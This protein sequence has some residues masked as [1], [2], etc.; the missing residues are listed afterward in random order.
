[1]KKREIVIAFAGNPNVGK[2]ALI[3]AISGAKLKIGNWPG[4][5]V[6]KRE[7]E[8]EFE[9][10]RFRLVDLPGIYSLTPYTL[11]ERIAQEF[12]LEERP[13][14][15][16]NV[17]DVTNIERN[18]YLTTQLA[19]LEIPMVIALNMWDEFKSKGF[20]LDVEMLSKILRVPCV[21]TAAVRG[22]GVDR[23]LKEVI[24]V[25]EDRV[26]PAKMRFKR[27]IEEKIQ[28]I[29]EALKEKDIPY[30][31]RWSAIK[32]LEKDE[33]FL[34]KISPFIS[35][36][37]MEIQKMRES[38]EEYFGEDIETVIAEQRYGYINGLVREVLKKP[39]ERKIEI[40]DLI[41]K[42]FL[43]RLLGMPI[44]FFLIYLVFKFTF[45]GSAPL[46]DWID[47]FIN[48][49]VAKWLSIVLYGVGAPQWLVSLLID[50]VLNGV[51]LVLSFVPLMFFL[52]FFMS[53]LEESGYMA[54]A[55]FLMDKI[56]HLVGLH[57]KSFIPMVIGFG[58]NVPAILA[59]R[60][61]ESEKDRKLTALLIPF[62]SCGARLPI[63]ALFTGLFFKKH[64]AEIVFLLYFMGVVV[65]LIVGMILQKTVFKGESHPFIMEL[66]PYRIP[67]L[68]MLWNSIWLRTRSFIRKAGTVIAVTMVI[69]WFFMNIPYGVSP[70]KTVLGRVART[71]SPVFYP[72]GFGENWKA[73]A[74]LIPGTVAKEIVVGALGQLYGIEEQK[75][76]VRSKTSLGEDLKDQAVELKDA[77][78]ASLKGILGGFKTTIFEMEE[79]E[80]TAFKKI[81]DEFTPLSA[82]SYMVFCL[83]WLPCVATLGAL[84]SEFGFGTLMLSLLLTTTVPYVVSALIYNIGRF[85]GY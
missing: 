85:W 49:F 4:V 74:A 62:M 47:G 67:T 25:Y 71:I 79:E 53:I 26:L 37:E 10:R 68:K 66:P 21:P 60:V 40:T 16:V 51:G 64:Q 7:A 77:V 84:Y 56:M 73:I 32:I 35:H 76:Q 33:F 19:E 43:N 2:T 1:M 80:S 24:K 12:L 5:T 27:I 39:V 11:E 72:L 42:V 3:N 31:L 70:E 20:Q 13:D 48:G 44:F 63:Y 17:I 57:G 52:Y 14:V 58:C 46:I 8:F 75:E 55:A 34:E 23:L 69:L 28:I 18:L 81:R 38:L 30:P 22:K 78:I 83:L 45:D 59:T 6:E 61:L 15:V 82:F 65:S 41:D 36:M 9:G 54:R 29:E 50:G